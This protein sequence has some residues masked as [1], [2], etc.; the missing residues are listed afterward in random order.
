MESMHAALTQV[1]KPAKSM[2]FDRESKAR[3][4]KLKTRYLANL[5]SIESQFTNFQNKETTQGRL[6]AVGHADH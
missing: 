2:C 3:L 4:A 5:E 1:D 6:I